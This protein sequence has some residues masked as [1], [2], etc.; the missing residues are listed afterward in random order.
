MVDFEFGM[1]SD[2]GEDMI[3]DLV[4]FVSKHSVSDDTINAMLELISKEEMYAEAA[5]TVV[6]ERVFAYWNRASW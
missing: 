1:F 4:K 3:Y 5:D 2:A 6:R